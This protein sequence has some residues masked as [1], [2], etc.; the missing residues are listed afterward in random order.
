MIFNAAYP[1]GAKPVVPVTVS[2]CRFV[3]VTGARDPGE[4]E[5][6]EIMPVEKPTPP[7]TSPLTFE[8]D[9][10]SYT[11]VAGEL[12]IP[13]HTMPD[14]EWE[15]YSNTVA[16]HTGSKITFS[17]I[18]SILVNGVELHASDVAEAFTYTIPDESESV[19]IGATIITN[20]S[21]PDGGYAEIRL[22]GWTPE[23]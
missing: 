3:D 2:I 8:I 20:W 5:G 16:A 4:T 21:V 14:Y 22:N 17:S 6:P 18:V 10:A 12:S 7:T 15:N 9:G 19:K 23:S 11:T 1:G 13:M